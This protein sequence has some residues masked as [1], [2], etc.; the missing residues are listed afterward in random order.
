MDNQGNLWLFGGRGYDEELQDY[1]YLNDLWK[2]DPSTN[3]WTWMKG[4][5]SS[6]IPGEYGSMGIPSELNTPGARDG[7]ASWK[8]TSGNLWLFGGFEYTR[9][10]HLGYFNDLWKYDP[11]TN[12]SDLD[13]R[14]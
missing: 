8:D 7:S 2:Y 4:D 13:S 6:N 1:Y 12:Q 3:Q 5:S 14:R 9:T 10:S 11:L